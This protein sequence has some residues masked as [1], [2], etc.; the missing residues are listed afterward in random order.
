MGFKGISV[1][2]T[3]DRILFREA[4]KD[5]TGTRVTSGTTSLRIY[6]LQSDGT[7]KSYDFNDNTFKTGA[8]TTATASMTHRTGN[9]STFNTGI[10]TYALTTLTGFTAGNIYIYSVDNTSATPTSV[11]RE[12]QFGGAEG[13][14]TVTGGGRLDVNADAIATHTTAATRL[15]NLFTAAYQAAVD[16]A[17]F[18]PTTTTFETTI[19]INLDRHTNQALYF[20]TGA[21][22]GF[23]T[24]I[25][26][27]SYTNS[28]VRL[29]VNTLPST[30]SDGD[31][32]LIFG[33]VA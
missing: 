22:A 20:V 27:Y 16:D 25:T 13:D 2:Q 8:L 11:E 32:F 17:T 10:W 24:G 19:T 5:S 6:E 31:T 1:R 23:T 30:P 21:N 7:L 18:S 3:G 9:N 14:L 33:K 29:T 4:L 26:G 15:K 12:F 28:K